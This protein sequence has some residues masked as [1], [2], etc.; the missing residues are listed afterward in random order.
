MFPVVSDYIQWT[1]IESSVF[2]QYDW[3]SNGVTFSS[4]DHIVKSDKNLNNSLSVW[5]L[6]DPWNMSTH[7]KS[8]WSCNASKHD[9]WIFFSISSRHELRQLTVQT[10]MIWEH[11][12]HLIYHFLDFVKQE[13]GTHIFTQKSINSIQH[14]FFFFK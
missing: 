7:L 9:T 14:T 2:H 13:S 1:H 3:F 11:N 12:T 6:D 8:T 10:F 4:T 5:I